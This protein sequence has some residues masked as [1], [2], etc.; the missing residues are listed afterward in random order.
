MK[1]SIVEEFP[2]RSDYFSAKAGIVAHF[3]KSANERAFAVYG[4]S[5]LSGSSRFQPGTSDIDLFVLERD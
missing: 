5:I 1:P 2:N 4:S 3:R